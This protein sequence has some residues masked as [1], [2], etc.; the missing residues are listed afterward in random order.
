MRGHTDQNE[1]DEASGGTTVVRS[2]PLKPDSPRS[3]KLV[4]AQY[5]RSEALKKIRE[6]QTAL[7]GLALT[8]EQVRLRRC[9]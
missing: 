6:L 1:R 8:P 9:V 4:E 3:R 7:D 5:D 2:A